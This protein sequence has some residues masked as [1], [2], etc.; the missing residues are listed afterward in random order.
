MTKIGELGEN[1]VARWLETRG[2]L[3]LARRWRCRSGEI[4][5]IARSEFSQTL[6]FIEVK[7]RG[8]GN[9]DA[10][11]L[12]AITPQKQAKLSLTAELFLAKFPDLVRYPCRFDVA[13]VI[14]RRC[15]QVPIQE[16]RDYCFKQSIKTGEPVYWGAYQLT[17]Q[18]Y[19]KSAFDSV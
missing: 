10:D 5:L 6:M 18:H 14:Y 9:W 12:L 13:L 15:Q 2:C 1:L 4:D 8:Y 16:S 3:I 17:L 11:G 7:T 19:I